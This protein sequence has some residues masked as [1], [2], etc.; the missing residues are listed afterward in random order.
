MCNYKISELEEMGFVL[1]DITLLTNDNSPSA[2][3][4]AQ[5]VLEKLTDEGHRVEINTTLAINLKGSV[6]ISQY[7]IKRND[8]GNKWVDFKG[9]SLP[10]HV[11]ISEALI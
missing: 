4:P 2:N 6:S 3:I 5:I 1:T 7:S 11:D 9:D 10:N 8:G